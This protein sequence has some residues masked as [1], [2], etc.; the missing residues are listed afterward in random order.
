MFQVWRTML[1]DKLPTGRGTLD[2]VE[3]GT[4]VQ[5][6]FLAAQVLLPVSQSWHA[7]WLNRPVNDRS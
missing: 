1:Q 6:S 2:S 7:A 5:V 3:S 4:R